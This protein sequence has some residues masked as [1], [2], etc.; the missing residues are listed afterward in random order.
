MNAK[1]NVYDF[2]NFVNILNVHGLAIEMAHSDFINVP[3]GVTEQS[4]FTEN[5]PLLDE[6][7]VAIF[8]RGSSKLFWKKKFLDDFKS[9]EFLQKKILSNL[10]KGNMIEFPPLYP[11]GAP[12]ITYSRKR[13][14][15]DNL[16]KIMPLNRRKF[17]TDLKTS[18][19][20]DEVSE[21]PKNKKA[22]RGF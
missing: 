12:V 16:L 15:I 2:A 1:K 13:G 10:L 21:S 6:I 22:K 11:C 20:N 17:W 4:K 18:N 8:C 19:K 14:I 9:A 3:P 5:K 7:S